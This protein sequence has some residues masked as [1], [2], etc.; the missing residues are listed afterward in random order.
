ML[1]KLREHQY[2]WTE[3]W[4][5]YLIILLPFSMLPIP[6]VYGQTTNSTNSIS[7]ES[8]S[9]NEGMEGRVAITLYSVPTGLSGYDITVSLRNGEVGDIIDVEFPEW[10]KLSDKSIMGSSV[11]LRAVDLEDRIK[12]GTTNVLLAVIIIGN[13]K[14][15]ESLIELAVNQMDDDYGD[16]IIPTIETGKIT[17]IGAPTQT[18]TTNTTT[19]IET[20]TEKSTN[21]RKETTITKIYL[22]L[23]IMMVLLFVTIFAVLTKLRKK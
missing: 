12:P 13:T 5:I 21:Q 14:Q 8:I 9:V 16:P 10:V 7:I 4:F 23:A 15:G 2:K 22:I 11:R 20:V 17:V 18:Q 6:R 3:V 19:N 1:S